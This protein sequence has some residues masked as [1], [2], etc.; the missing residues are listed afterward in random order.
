MIE[1]ELKALVP[2]LAGARRRV[3]SAGGR[4]TFSGR[5]ED[6]RYDRSE[7][8]LA[9]VDHVLRLRVYRDASGQ[10]SRASLDWKGPSSTTGAYKQREELNC[11]VASD[12]EQLAQILDRLG[13][14][15]TM[16]IDRQIWQYELED[17]VVRF[18]RYP[19]MDDL[20][21]VEGTPDAIER[22]ITTM[23]LERDSFTAERLPDFVRRFEARTGRL[24]AL[25]D[26]ELAGA[27]RYDVSNA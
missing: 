5:L 6:R 8:S 20:V 15:V 19:R 13:F 3:E 26:A 23:E 2:D 1:T 17:A 21:E 4:M 12:P 24:A 7:L 27:V 18:E 11:E 25:S 22:A 9:S 16:Q 14:T 10:V